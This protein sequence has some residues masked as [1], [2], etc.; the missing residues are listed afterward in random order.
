MASYDKLEERGICIPINET[1]FKDT[2]RAHPL[3][4]AVDADMKDRQFRNHCYKYMNPKF[5]LPK[6][7]IQ[8]LGAQSSEEVCATVGSGEV[9]K[10]GGVIMRTP[11]S[12]P[13]SGRAQCHGTYSRRWPPPSRADL[14][15]QIL[16]DVKMLRPYFLHHRELL[17]REWPED[18]ITAIKVGAKVIVEWC[19]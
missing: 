2:T 16:A 10:G 7:G 13:T 6:R 19:R 1:S 11:T 5:P 9:L 15:H 4:A 17:G 18:Y 3:S 14:Q 12:F 8:A